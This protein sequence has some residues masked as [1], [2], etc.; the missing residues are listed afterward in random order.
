M[1]SFGP[2]FQLARFGMQI[3]LMDVILLIGLGRLITDRLIQ[4][5]GFPRIGRA[6][7]SFLLFLL[8][9][10][11]IGVI[12]NP[13][14]LVISE[15]RFFF[16]LGIVWLW[17]ILLADSF[18]VK[19]LLVYALSLGS[20]LM[21]LKSLLMLLGFFQKVPIDIAQGIL[22]PSPELGV[23]RVLLIGA[24]SL[25]P[26]S[27]S[28]LLSVSLYSNERRRWLLIIPL[29]SASLALFLGFTRAA[30]IGA[31]GGA[32]ITVWLGGK[33][34]RRGS[35]IAKKFLVFLAG[36][37]LMLLIGSAVLQ[38][39]LN[40][41]VVNLIYRRFSGQYDL[42]GGFGGLDYRMNEASVVWTELQRSPLLGKGLGGTYYW[43]DFGSTYINQLVWTHVGWTW[44]A[45]KGGLFG[46]VLFLSAFFIQ[47][48]KIRG[49]LD[50]NSVS[51]PLLA[52]LIGAF[53]ANGLG[54]I[55][56]NPFASPEG[57]A[58]LGAGLG[59]MAITGFRHANGEDLPRDLPLN[60]S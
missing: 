3:N 29:V 52:G 21:A 33:W 16:Y 45:L 42:G 22:F 5:L 51:I 60:F 23:G 59:I 11:F 39:S 41:D 40:L 54:A 55:G 9:A 6:G 28:I 2:T 56:N 14:D 58:L 24:D 12:N 44:L 19:R 38:K 26:A 8:L 36:G 50:A 17:V 18:D 57:S 13:L 27:I 10:T 34:A 20:I 7:M 15:F 49:R 48:K 35:E 47:Y 32:L 4:H 25:L 53:A 43:A 30:W 31:L 46:N 1:M 37:L